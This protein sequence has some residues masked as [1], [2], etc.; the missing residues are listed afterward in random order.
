MTE[1]YI[2]K[3][4]CY[5]QYQVQCFQSSQCLY[6]STQNLETYLVLDG[7][8]LDLVVQ[9]CVQ[10]Q[11]HTLLLYILVFIRILYGFQ[12]FQDSSLC[13]GIL[14]TTWFLGFLVILLFKSFSR[15]QVFPRHNEVISSIP[16]PAR[17]MQY[18]VTDAVQQCICTESTPTMRTWVDNPTT[19]RAICCEDLQA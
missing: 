15:S 16:S 17:H 14:G 3:I 13:Q 18:C 7:Q 9:N 6:F 11:S 10:G 1:W 2:S 12:L 4:T 8:N 5:Q 19:V